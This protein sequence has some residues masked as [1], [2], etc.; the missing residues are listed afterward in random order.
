LIC[1]CAI[2]PKINPSGEHRNAQI[3]EAIAHG[4]VLRGVPNPGWPYGGGAPYGGGEGGA[5]YGGGG[6]PSGGG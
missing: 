4:F 6:A 1:D 5:P 2:K 3:S